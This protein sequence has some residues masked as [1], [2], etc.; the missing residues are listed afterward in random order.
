MIRRF[1]FRIYPLYCI[2]CCCFRTVGVVSLSAIVCVIDVIQ[3][4]IIRIDGPYCL[5]KIL[6]I[7]FHFYD[8][9]CI[10]FHNLLVVVVS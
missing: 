4:V 2:S 7:K 3:L 6:T 1:V 10:G 9:Y 8:L 5:Y